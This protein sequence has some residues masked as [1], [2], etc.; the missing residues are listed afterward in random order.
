V[1]RGGATAAEVLAF[2]RSVRD[3]VLGELGV[4]LVPEPIALGFTTEELGDLC[5]P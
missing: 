4:R 2:A 3:E 1:N 5:A